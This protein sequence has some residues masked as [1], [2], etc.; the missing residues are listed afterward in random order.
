MVGDVEPAAL[1]DDGRGV[2]D[3]PGLGLALRAIGLRLVVET[4]LFLELVT[5]LRAFVFVNGHPW[6]LS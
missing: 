5:A 6:Y 1:E 4:L 2:K 3:A